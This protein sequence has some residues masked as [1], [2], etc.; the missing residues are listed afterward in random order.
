MTTDVSSYGNA[1]A[2]KY[3]DCMGTS[4][5]SCGAAWIEVRPTSLKVTEYWDKYQSPNYKQ[6]DSFSITPKNRGWTY[7]AI[8][9]RAHTRYRFSVDAPR[10]DDSCMQISEIQLLDENGN[11][12]SSGYTLGYDSTTKP[13]DGGNMYP[14]NEK[15]EYAADG[16]TSTKW[17]DWRA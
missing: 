16:K 4:N 11:R 7:E 2:T 13:S 1:N 15:P 6:Y 10:S 8:G 9:E 5:A 12:I 14:S 17:L 3:F